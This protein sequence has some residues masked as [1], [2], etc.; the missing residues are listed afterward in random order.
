M[1]LSMIFAGAHAHASALAEQVRGHACMG[2][3]ETRAHSIKIIRSQAFDNV[4]ELD[5]G[6][7]RKHKQC[8]IWQF[9]IY[10]LVYHHI[11]VCGH[12]LEP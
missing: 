3:T 1:L 7:N 5:K 6:L 9:F 12:S 8:I 11:P 2:S 10:F 4:L